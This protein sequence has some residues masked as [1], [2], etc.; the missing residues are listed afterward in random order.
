MNATTLGVPAWFIAMVGA[1]SI[2]LELGLST[3]VGLFGQWFL[4]STTRV[5][6]RIALAVTMLLALGGYAILSHPSLKWGVE[7][8]RIW[9]VH[10]LQWALVALG[11]SSAAGHTGGAPGTN[12]RGPGSTPSPEVPLKAPVAVMLF[13]LMLFASVSHAAPQEQRLKAPELTLVSPAPDGSKPWY[14]TDNLSTAAGLS[15]RWLNG[16][17]ARFL[18]PRKEFVFGLYNAWQLT[19]HVDAIVNVELGADTKANG[20]TAGLRWVVKAPK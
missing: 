13:A 7:D 10:G 12:S 6:N 20:F 16:G 4:K 17:D 11:V 18:T 1:Y 3:T 2:S 5:D 15:Y 14:S 8:W 9:L 19:E